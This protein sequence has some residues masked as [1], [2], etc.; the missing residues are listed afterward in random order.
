MLFFSP[1]SKT[2]SPQ[3]K[4]THV[5]IFFNFWQFPSNSQE[6]VIDIELHADDIQN[7]QIYRKASEKSTTK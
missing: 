5:Y 6:Q 2:F 1:K 3:I 4:L 7:G